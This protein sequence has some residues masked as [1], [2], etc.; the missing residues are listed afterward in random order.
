MKRRTTAI[1][2][3]LTIAA[4]LTFQPSAFSASTFSYKQ[5][6]T[7][8][9]G[10]S[11]SI[12]LSMNVWIQGNNMRIEANSMGIEVITITNENGTYNYLPAQNLATKIPDTGQDT[13]FE[14][15][16]TLS[17]YKSKLSQLNAKKVGTET[18]DGY[19]CDVYTYIDPTTNAGV[20][21]WVWQEKYFP[22]KM[23]MEN[24]A[25][26]TAIITFSDIK[27]DEPIPASKFELPSGAK[28]LDM[29]SLMGN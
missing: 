1:I 5:T 27:I 25:M 15:A 28:V 9:K 10:T 2:A 7:T 6:T 21:A 20:K 12:S 16:K 22:I 11:F 14:F 29:Q 17:T 24:T 8:G 23:E 19:T 18:V 26:G 4:L 13:N 3:L